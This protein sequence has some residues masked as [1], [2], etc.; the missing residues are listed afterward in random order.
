MRSEFQDIELD[1]VR[2]SLVWEDFETLFSGLQFDE[3]D[4][5]LIITSG[6]CNVLN[7]LLRPV[8]SVTAVEIN[9]V[10]NL[11]L[12]LKMHTIRDHDYTTFA[13]LLGLYGQNAV[14]DAWNK[15]KKTL[16]KKEVCFW[17]PYFQ[18]K[19]E[20]LLL[21]GKLER[22]ILS[23]RK[24]LDNETS[25]RLRQLVTYSS[26]TAQHEYF[27]NHLDSSTFRKLFINFFNEQN[28]SKGRDPKL[29]KYAEEPA[30][31]T[32]YQR[33]V[34]F[35]NTFLVKDNFYFR[36]IFFGLDYLE[37]CLPACYQL[38]NFENIKTNLHK[39]RIVDGE[40][41]EYLL[42][43]NGREITRASLSNI[44]EYTSR[45]EFTTVCRELAQQ[46]PSLKFI[47]WNLLQE[48][49]ARESGVSFRP[50]LHHHNQSSC[51]YLKNACTMQL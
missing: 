41:I 3:D 44:F 15:L 33:L 20:G 34:S 2:Y 10:Q 1:Q 49:S 9:P 23:F 24:L 37:Y 19:P 12:A 40:A 29:F 27:M 30:G 17:E 5:L 47:Y 16:P 50:V 8:A 18:S 48:Q 11:L 31:E 14:K 22:Y 32:F 25:S 43:E 51:F 45:S 6:G 36:F 7:S 38:G 4:H 35:I 13:S 46:R 28:L 21:F 26:V 42:S 39:I